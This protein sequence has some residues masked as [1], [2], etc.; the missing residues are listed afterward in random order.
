MTLTAGHKRALIATLALAAVVGCATVPQSPT[1]GPAAGPTSAVLA[2]QLFAE[3]CIEPAPTFAGSKAALAA[4]G[5]TQNTITNTFYLTSENLSIKL[6]DSALA[7]RGVLSFDDPAQPDTCSIVFA[8]NVDGETAASQ[9]A[10]GTVAVT[11]DVPPGITV[12]SNQRAG[13]TYVNAR[14]TAQ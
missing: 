10:Q 1:A 7:E 2:G 12:T 5:F 14:L 9:L 11:T 3:I 8:T 4:R 6:Q 13:L